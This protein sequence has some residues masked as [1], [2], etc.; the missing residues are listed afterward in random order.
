[1]NINEK[2]MNIQ[3]QLKA[4]KSQRN[5]FGKYNYRSQED[6]LEAV[7]PLLASVKAILTL[8]DTIEHIGDSRFYV[9]ATA[10]LTDAEKGEK[11]EV[12]AY[13][14]EDE[15]QKGMA[16]AQVTGSV[17]SYARKYALNGLFCIDDTKDSD[18]TNE[19]G[20]GEQKKD[21]ELNKQEPINKT[22]QPKPKTLKELKDEVIAI[23]QV[24]TDAG[25]KEETLATIKKISGSQNPLNLKDM[26]TTSGVLAAL[27]LL[28]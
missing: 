25:K 3:S 17:S 10:T 13:A 4:H 19:H 20:K 14:R 15:T 11:I 22:P 28:K 21:I 1:M 18:A 8:S 27:K 24:L 9:K 16:S 23:C 26:K 12:T 7:K 5:T 2:L 6:I